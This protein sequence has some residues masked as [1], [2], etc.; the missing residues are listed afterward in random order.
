MWRNLASTAL[1]MMVL[2]LVVAGGLIAWGKTQYEEPGPL[3]VAVCLEVKSGASFGSVSEALA[4]DGAISSPA[5]FRLGAEYS[6]KTADLKA[7]SFLVPE[8]ASMAEITDIVTRGGASTCGTEIVYRIG[9]TNTEIQLRE[10][11]P[12]TQRFVTQVE[13][14]PDSESIPAEYLRLRDA[15]GTRFRIS[16]AEGATNW[17]IVDA[18]DKADFLAGSVANV[19]DE[20]LLAPDS[21]EVVKGEE[22]GALVARMAAAQETRLAEAWANRADD[23]PYG[24]PQEAL[25]MASIVEKETGIADERRD[26]ASVFLNRLDRGMRL[27][28]DPT[29]IYGITGGKGSLG[30]GLR[31]SELRAETSYNT[32]VIDGLP[33]TPI[34]NP[35]IASI[36]AALNPTETDYIFFVAKTLNPADGHVFS[37]TL[38]EHNANVAKLRAL[39]EAQ[40]AQ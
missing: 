15:A 14:A 36:E 12:A 40:G 6:G 35:G 34:A 19:P 5:I 2:L 7:G 22:R 39:E 31:Q 25:I 1:S 27:Q 20:G 28:T 8:G 29:V 37:S 4:A 26:V 11:D 9:I 30:R 13:F 21:Y 18:L 10:L 3:D 24:T 16:I 33:P 38:E 17:Q 32:Y 23:L